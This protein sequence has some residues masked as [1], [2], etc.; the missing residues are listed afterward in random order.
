MANGNERDPDREPMDRRTRILLISD[1]EGLRF[2]R[3]LLLRKHGYDVEALSSGQFLAKSELC[4]CDL[5]ILCQSLESDRALLIGAI[6]RRTE[7]GTVLLRVHP[8]RRG[9][10]PE[11]DLCVAGFDGPGVLLNVLQA[12]V[13]THPKVA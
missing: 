2:S 3:E 5:A 11:F 8:F 7:P 10:E 12:F 1:Y 9:L 4:Q 6:L 13:W